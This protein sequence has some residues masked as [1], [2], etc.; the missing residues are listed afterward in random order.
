MNDEN[1]EFDYDVDAAEL[2]HNPVAWAIFSF[3]TDWFGAYPDP[4]DRILCRM[5]VDLRPPGPWTNDEIVK[6]RE[7]L[8]SLGPLLGKTVEEADMDLLAEVERAL[9]GR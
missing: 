4:V 1:D 7:Q 8:L 5:V 6:V 3:M 9:A 2:L